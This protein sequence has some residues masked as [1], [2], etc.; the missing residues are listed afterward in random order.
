MVDDPATRRAVAVLSS[1]LG[2]EP[3][4]VVRSPGRVNLVGEHTDYND[5]FALPLAIDRDL[6][7]A[8]ARR[9]DAQVR[10]VSE[11]DGQVHEL[12]LDSHAQRPNW[13]G[14]TVYVQGMLAT[15]WSPQAEGAW[16]DPVGFDAAVASDLPA[17]AGLSSSA[18]LELA[19]ARA[20]AA[21]ADVPH[22]PTAAALAGQR[23]ENE[24]VGVATGTMDQMT[25]AHGRRGH[26]LLVDCRDMSVTPVALPS[27]LDVVVLDTGARRELVGSAY[28]ERR[29]QCEQGAARL[30]VSSLRDVTVD[31]LDAVDRLP[32]PLA[33]RVR[34]VVTENARVH[35]TVAGLAAAD[36][37]AV[38]VALRESHRSLRDDFEVSG[39]ELDTMA[40][41][42][43]DTAGIVGARMTG[44]GFAGAVVAL[45]EAGAV[46]LDGIIA[47]YRG[48]HDLPARALAVQAAD[49]TSV[50]SP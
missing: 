36:R 30:G 5:G 6:V 16:G 25:V 32:A 8:V 21:L 15:V 13:P 22:D 45:A 11:L 20:V 9:P 38:G 34:H 28:D 14:W 23:A 17:G 44:G 33:A 26:V 50:V 1:A 24:W 27:D 48:V 46:D 18:A 47:R 49:G 7:M 10:L 37:E 40:D 35:D 39:P 2:V 4:V 42:A 43:N 31:D 41:I 19:V 3:D 29:R 12:S